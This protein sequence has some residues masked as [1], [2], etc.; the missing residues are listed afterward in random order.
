MRR[1]K[2]RIKL[3][4]G[5]TRAWKSDARYVFLVAGTG[6]GKTWFGP[7][8]MY[9]EIQRHPRGNY[10][11]VAPTYSLLSRVTFPEAKGFLDKFAPGEYKAI[12]RCYYLPT[13]GK[14]FFGSADRPLG[15]EGVHCIA[16]WLDEA[17]QMKR[18]AWDV[19]QRRT[20][21]HKGKVLGTTTPYNLG[22]L[23]T[24]IFD[25]WKEGDRDYFV[26]QFPSILNPAYPREEFER[27]RKTMPEWKFKMFYLGMFT[28]PEGLI[29][30][31][32]RQEKH[33]VQP[34][35]IPREWKR[36]IG[37][38]WGFGEKHPAAA[39]WVAVAPG[40]K[41]Y[42]YREYYRQ[43]RIAEEIAEDIKKLSAG[44]RIDAVA[45]DPESPANIE[46]FKRHKLPARSA[47][48]AVEFGIETVTGMFRNDRLFAFKG[49]PNWLDEIEN[50]R[51]KE[52]TNVPLKEY[53]HLM[54][55]MRYA[56]MEVERGI[57][58]VLRPGIVERE[59]VWRR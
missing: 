31:D 11:V 48:N 35:A 18:E 52:G 4:P 7:I 13:G 1:R 8:W 58:P 55:A 38:D 40:R 32:F 23:K 16:V 10:L 29:Y 6:G 49:L 47:N 30:Q 50:Y 43:G 33:L 42:I 36:V 34:F 19:A 9:R 15:L 2:A 14:V 25:K 17:G 53:D 37:V 57:V 39:V 51:W 46:V 27:A 54:D 41:L 56:V 3:H 45:C 24:E 20:G 12:E 5:Q 21:L 22:W 59:S 26:S 28:R 44:E